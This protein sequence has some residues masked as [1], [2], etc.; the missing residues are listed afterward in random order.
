[1]YDHPECVDAIVAWLRRTDESVNTNEGA[2]FV[3]KKFTSQ[4]V[5]FSYASRS[6]RVPYFCPDDYDE[7]KRMLRDRRE[8]P[9][10]YEERLRLSNEQFA[11]HKARGHRVK[12]VV[13]RSKDFKE[14]CRQKMKTP[15]EEM[16]W[17]FLV[18]LVPS[19]TVDASDT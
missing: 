10:A 16:L 19:E 18:E 5:A 15:N 2:S 6:A 14:Y 8:F 1:L 17:W 3:P 4:L 13:V 11:E 9:E 12:K 7:I